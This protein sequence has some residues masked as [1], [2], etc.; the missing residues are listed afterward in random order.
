MVHETPPS[1]LKLASARLA[2]DIA[3]AVAALVRGEVIG[4]PTETVYGLAA[5]ASNAAAV[6]RIFALKGRPADHPVIVHIADA[7][8]L[9]RWARDVP[10]AARTLAAAFWPGPLTLILPRQSSVHDAV[11]GGQ[12]TVG[13]RCPAHPLALRVLRDFDGGL[14]AP[15]ANRFGHVSPT[16]AAHV[17][18]EFGDAVPLVLDGGDCEVGIESTIVAFTGARPRILRPGLITRTALE[19]AVG[20]VD[21]EVD[22]DSPRA[23]GTL[24]AHYAPRT[25]MLL[26]ARAALEAELGQQ[27]A[28]GK[29]VRVLVLGALPAD[30]EGLALPA[31]AAG[32]AH[33]LY[34]AMR[35]L[36]DGGQL[37]LVERPPGGED[38]LA[39]HDRL[40]RAAAGAEPGDDVP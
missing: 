6:Q 4:L 33:A 11:T 12:D 5:D 23:S 17:R 16:N 7:S 34:A 40:R 3:N 36:D 15:S 2:V 25:P 21:V 29:R 38:W 1:A 20:P 32:Y 10:E 19:A 18:A 39:V 8:E 35:A 28:L 30:A 13:L 31:R 24:E 37:L 26:L 22:S 27:A 14:A 9:P